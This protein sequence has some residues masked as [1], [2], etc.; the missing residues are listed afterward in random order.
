M[1]K[2]RADDVDLVGPD[3]ALTGL[4]KSVQESALEAE[5]S[6]HLGY[7]KHEVPGR[8]GG[9]SRNGTRPQDVLT[10]G[11][12]GSSPLS[13]TRIGYDLRKRNRCIDDVRCRSASPLENPSLCRLPR[14]G[15]ALRLDLQEF[16]LMLQLG[17]R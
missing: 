3:G 1:D 16:P 7:D 13:S 14:A 11:V 10:E 5:M 8:D 12:R 15:R 6:E 17:G 4:T 9:N 2:V